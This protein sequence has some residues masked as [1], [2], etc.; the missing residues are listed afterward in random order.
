MDRGMTLSEQLATKE[1]RDQ[2]IEKN[3]PLVSRRV[4]QFLNRNP[5]LGYLKHDISSAA[6]LGLVE[7]V[8]DLK[9]GAIP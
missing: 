2:F 1:A 7:A 9:N 6:K 4:R 5:H 8:D 3:M